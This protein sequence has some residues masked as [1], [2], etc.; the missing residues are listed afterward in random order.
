MDRAVGL[1]GVLDALQ[2]NVFVADLDLTLVYMNEVA[3]STLLRIEGE[4]RAVFG[5]G[6]DDL[7]GGS[8]HRFHR[9]P[10]R[11]ERIL[12]SPS[13]LPH[14]AVFRFGQVTLKTRING[15]WSPEGDLLGYVVAWEDVSEEMRR[16][17]ELNRTTCMVENSPA[18]VMAADTDLVIRYMNPASLRTLR[19]V[20]AHLPVK[21][22]QV[23]GQS[24]DIFHRSPE[25][26]RRIVS[27]PANLPHRTTFALG[28]EH[29]RF[30]VTAIYDQQKTYLGPMVSWELVT[31]KVQAERRAKELA[32]A[33]TLNAQ[34]LA[35]ASEQ[36]TQVSRQMASTAEETSVQASVV[37]SAADQVS[38]N[39]QTVAAGAEQM[40]ASIKEIAKNA[41][42]AA[43]VAGAGVQVATAT[44]AT[45]GKLGESSG[46]VGK[47]VK[48]ITSIAQQTKLLALNATIEAARAGEAGKGFAVVA[49]EV[50]ELAKETARATEEIGQKIDAIQADARGAVGAIGEISA[51]IGKIDGLQTA[52]AGAVEEQT[53]TTAE[54]ARNVS[55]AARGGREIAKNISGVATAAQAT[56]GGAGDTQKAAADLA[57]MAGELMKLVARLA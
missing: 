6:I 36:L 22:D 23:V 39:L 57:T 51:I 20:E 40:G 2:A 47:V 29:V 13:A 24:I 27:D 31:E 9:D 34:T 8:I 11:V 28:P 42:E 25:R 46:E 16:L 38:K 54:I 49:N 30:E 4:V 17:A 14:E 52:I 21:A 50:K 44:T 53:A 26:I 7:L 37:S 43:R 5:V 48:V 41:G 12:R 33:I 32:D 19:G 15:A 18:N 55:E 3:R 10:R 56:T 45:V 1:R 35:G